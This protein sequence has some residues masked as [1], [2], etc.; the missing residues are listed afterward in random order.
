VPAWSNLID[1]KILFFHTCRVAVRYATQSR[2][3]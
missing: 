1:M 2:S 3:G